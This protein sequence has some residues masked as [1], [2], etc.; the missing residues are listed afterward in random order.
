MEVD[1][2]VLRD[3]INRTLDMIIEARGTS[4]TIKNGYYWNISAE[5][6]YNVTSD[7]TDLDIGDLEYEYELI[8]KIGSSPEGQCPIVS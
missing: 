2:R 6:L 3:S 1:L 5:E 7:P 4:L 8:K